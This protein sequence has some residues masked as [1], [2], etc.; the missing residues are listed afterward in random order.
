MDTPRFRRLVD[1]L[2]DAMLLPAGERA[3]FVE[4]ACGGD[5]AL[6]AEAQSLLA[7]AQV[8]SFEA[9][10]ARIGAGVDRAAESLRGAGP[11][12]PPQIGPYRIIGVLGEGGMGLVYHAEQTSPIRREVA[13]KMVRG[14]LRGASARARFEAERQ[15]LAVMNHP[16]IARIFDAGATEDG[17]PYFAM[18]LVRGE[19]IT[20]FC[21]GQHLDVDARIDLF[22]E[23]CRA[24]QH[25][26][27]NGII[28]RDLKPSNILVSSVDGRA[29]PRVIDF[30]I[31]K[32]VEAAAGAE[33]MH[34]AF[35]SV[36]GTL[37]YM[38]PEQAA[39]GTAPVDTR[40]DVYSLGVV[41]YEL[42]TGSLPFDSASLRGAGAVE[43]QRLIRDTDPPT[44]ARRFTATGEREAIARTRSTDAR[45]LQRRLNGDLGWVIMKALEKDPAR[46]YQSASDLAADLGRLRV[47]QPVEAGPPSRRYRAGRFVRRHRTAVVAASVVVVAL[48]A[49]IAL[50]TTG[51][52]RARRAQVRAENEARRATLI[53]DFLTGMLA[54]A[55]PDK[56]RGREVTVL[57][58]VDST[59]VRI[60]R[61]N[62][63]AGDPLVLAD[64]VHAVGETYRSLD[65]YDRAIPL[66]ERAVALKR[67]APGDNRES[68]LISL[69]KLSSTKAQAGD[70]PGAIATQTEV[71][72]LTERLLGKENDRYSAWLSNLGNMYADVGDLAAAERILRES[73]AIDRR[74]LGNDHEDMP[75]SINNLATVLVDQGNCEDA[76]P[77]HEESIAM[78][79]RYYGEP[80]AEMAVGLSNLSRALDCAGRYGAAEIAADSALAMSTTVFGPGHHRTATCRVRLAEVLMHT[81]RADAAE[82]LLCDAVVVFGAIDARFWRTGDARARLG[83]ALIAQGRGP[84]GIRELEAGWDILTET[85]ETD[86]PRSREIAGV[87]AGY[88]E[89]KTE[90]ALAERWRLRAAGGSGEQRAP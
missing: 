78:R 27:I 8:T 58:V 37:E 16:G 89:Q 68:M 54:E 31:A 4:R 52:V 60:E 2:G 75:I 84:E 57:E 44:P 1:I 46:R 76:I 6:L 59:A 81:N 21:D 20:A 18:E 28:H 73:L 32:A 10:T 36:I 40:S 72:G 30:G 85:T 43:A 35:G 83:E 29:Q 64:V 17:V 67:S 33:T 42:V 9:V 74:V 48:I 55:R 34:T 22:V 19:P 39:G 3:A 66:F 86:T 80:S 63:F 12:F 13:L 38:S 49:G 41:L 69:N 53:K 87:I 90:R 82:P 47:D 61:E 70:L 71:V 45:S 79:H 50:A 7:E 15:A 65:Q 11:A 56:S 51:F 5:A 88:Y 24:V 25:A 26:H 77:L 23:V 14:G 62:P